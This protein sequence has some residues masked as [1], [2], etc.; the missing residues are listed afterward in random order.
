MPFNLNQIIIITLAGYLLLGAMITV[1]LC[2]EKAQK[3]IYQLYRDWFQTTTTGDKAIAILILGLP[4]WLL[5]EAYVL[6][7]IRKF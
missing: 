4:L 7:S 5:I 3:E 1:A 2:F 6:S